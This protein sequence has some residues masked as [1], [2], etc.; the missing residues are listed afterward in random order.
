MGRWRETRLGRKVR[1]GM[2]NYLDE[3]QEKGGEK[4]GGRRKGAATAHDGWKKGE[5]HN[6]LFGMR[7]KVYTTVSDSGRARGRMATLTPCQKQKGR[8]GGKEGRESRRGK[9]GNNPDE[10]ESK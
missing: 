8:G 5:K 7:K 1:P 9:V 4:G 2:Q 3:E 6:L 10:A